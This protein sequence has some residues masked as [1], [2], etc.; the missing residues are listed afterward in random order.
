MLQ[1]S[2]CICNVLD[3]HTHAHTHTHTHAQRVHT[4]THSHTHSCAHTNYV[5]T[6]LHAHIRNTTHITY[7]CM[8]THTHMYTDNELPDYIMVMLVNKKTFHQISS[9]L[10][11]FLGEHTAPFIEWLQQSVT[12]GSLTASKKNKA[13]GIQYM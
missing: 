12:T 13:P 9:D 8:Y 11:L 10:Q 6:H 1:G 4:S 3:T 7:V 5:H 2:M